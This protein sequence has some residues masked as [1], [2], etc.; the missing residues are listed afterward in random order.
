MGWPIINRSRPPLHRGERCL[1]RS[2]SARCSNAGAES[3][4]S[5]ESTGQASVEDDCSRG[6]PSNY[7][8]M[9]L[10]AKFWRSSS[11]TRSPSAEGYMVT[12]L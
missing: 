10:F 1:R 4:P 12:C 8:G 7:A 9:S 3:S 6:F 11:I 2:D 5:V